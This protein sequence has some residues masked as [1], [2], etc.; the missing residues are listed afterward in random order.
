MK[1]PRAGSKIYNGIEIPEKCKIF[2][3]ELGRE[4]RVVCVNDHT[5][6]F[7]DSGEWVNITKKQFDKLEL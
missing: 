7:L 3:S 4:F 2:K 6:Q 1:K 5:I